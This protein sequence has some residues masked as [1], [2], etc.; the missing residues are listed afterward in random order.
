MKKAKVLSVYD[1]GALEDTPF[2]GATGFS[3]LVEVDGQRTL[4]DTGMRGRYLIHN[5]DYLDVKPDMIDRVV[6]SQIGRAHV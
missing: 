1:E 5:L 6:I 4:F 2:I 3:V